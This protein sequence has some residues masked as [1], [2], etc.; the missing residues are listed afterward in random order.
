ML[1]FLT[2]NRTLRAYCAPQTR[3]MLALGFSSGL[4]FLMVGNTF[5]YWL[6]DKGISLTEIGIISGVGLAYSLKFLWAPVIDRMDAPVFGFLG[7]R[8]G[9]MILSQLLVAIG[10]FAMAATGVSGGTTLLGICALV[11]AFASSTQDIVIDAWRIE[12]A[13]DQEQ[14]GLLTSAETFG[15]RVALLATDAVILI[16]ADAVG[17][18]ISYAIYGVL[19]G[20]GIISALLATESPAAARIAHDEKPIS[21]LK[22]LKDAILGPFIVFF[23]THGWLA[24]L[25]LGAIALYRLPDFFMGPMCNPFYHD[26]GFTKTHV[27]EIRGSIGLISSFLGIAAGG[28]AVLRMGNIRALITGGILQALSIAA[29]SLLA[30]VG[31]SLSL[32]AVIMVADGFA[33]SFAGVVLVAYMSSLTSLGYTATQYALLAS[34]YAMAG[35]ILKTLSGIVVDSLEASHGLM[36]AYGIFFL[37]AGLIG[38]PSILL[39]LCLSGILKRRMKA[40]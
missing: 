38:L 35:K 21:T 34:A 13:G 9:W 26:L 22:G 39:F 6:R 27:G 12:N 15:Y 30:W 36:D 19:M 37:A 28:F 31:P 32:F 11:V 7:R 1:D 16:L 23:K 18:R 25:M 14:L 2:R 5:G 33:I 4:P 10:L 17:W 29:Y 24:L 3:I 40:S 8:R 20:V